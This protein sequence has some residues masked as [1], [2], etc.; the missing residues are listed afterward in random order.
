MTSDVHVFR[1]VA[2]ADVRQV[3][4]IHMEDS[5]LLFPRSFRLHCQ[6]IVA[7]NAQLS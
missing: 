2:S 4:V 3:N 7:V 1:P 5:S 6:R